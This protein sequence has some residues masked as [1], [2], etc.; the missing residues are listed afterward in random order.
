MPRRLRQDLHIH[1]VFS[2]GDRAIAEEQR[3]ELIAEVRH[4]EIIGISDHLEYVYECMPVYCDRVRDF[5]FHVGVEVN[6][7]EW[8]PQ[9]LLAPVEYYIYHCRDRRED[10]HGAEVLLATGRPVIIAHPSALDTDLN[11]VPPA[12]LVELNNR[13]L[14]RSDWRADLAPFVSR[15]R[16]VI[17][18]DAHQPHWLNQNYA[19]YVAEELGIQEQVLF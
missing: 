17:S 5:G 19:R 6:G 2:S 10:Y 9:A 1:T 4:A 11:L 7:V 8:V 3:L 18:S 15:F 14:W 13:Y 12:C 16:F